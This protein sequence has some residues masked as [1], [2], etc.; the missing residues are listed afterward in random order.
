MAFWNK[1]ISLKGFASRSVK[2]VFILYFFRH[3]IYLS[4]R[5]ESEIGYVAQRGKEKEIKN[6]RR[7]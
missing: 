1:E 7:G 2:S 5:N 4:M 6:G 3:P